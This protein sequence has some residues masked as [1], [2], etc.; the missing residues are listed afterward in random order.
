MLKQFARRGPGFYSSV[1]QAIYGIRGRSVKEP[2]AVNHYAGQQRKFCEP[3]GR[4]ERSGNEH[5]SA[6]QIRLIQQSRNRFSV[7][8]GVSVAEARLVAARPI[9]FLFQ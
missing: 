9:E 3:S 6:A 2:S 1:N 4:L 7:A 5:F 8:F